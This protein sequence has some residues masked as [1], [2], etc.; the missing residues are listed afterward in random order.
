MRMEL[1]DNQNASTLEAEW[2]GWSAGLLLLRDA[3]G[4]DEV[5]LR[6]TSTAKPSS[7]G[8]Y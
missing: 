3:I 7:S 5:V 4:N 1:D 6:N 8:L 2:K